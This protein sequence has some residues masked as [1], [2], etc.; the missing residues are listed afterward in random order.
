MDKDAREAPRATIGIPTR[1]GERTLRYALRSACQQD[2]PN[3]EIVVSENDSQD[4]TYEIAAEFA[5]EDD[6]IRIIRQTES[7]KA[8]ENFRA[9]WRAGKGKYFVWLADDDLLEKDF[10]TRCVATLEANPEAVL[11]FGELIAFSDYEEMSDA[12]PYPLYDFATKGQPGWRRLIKA[13][14][15]GYE[16]KGLFLREALENYGWYEHTVSP[17]WPLLTYFMMFGEVVVSPGAL[18]YTGSALPE[19]GEDRAR[20][21]SFSTIERFPTATLSWRCGLA[22]RDAATAKG[23]RRFP[24]LDAALTFVS[25]IWLNR[26]SI[27]QRAS[28]EASVKIQRLRGKDAGGPR[29]DL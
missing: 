27:V 21:Q 22:A 2:Y 10:V 23:R 5:A 14:D 24:L 28:S 18:S 8:L 15:G 9:V 4:R 11:T 25:L 19:S 26:R 20:T 16:V 3:L 12:V 7:L 17:D 13:R 29:V 1:N 6:R